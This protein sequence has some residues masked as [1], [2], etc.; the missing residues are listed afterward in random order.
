MHKLTYKFC[1]G[2]ISAALAGGS[3]PVMA[4]TMTAEGT[5]T[6][7]AAPAAEPA[8]EGSGAEGEADPAAPAS[9]E[10]GTEPA[11]TDPAE[12]DPAAPASPE[13]GTDPAGTDP[14]ETDPAEGTE[15]TPAEGGGTEEPGKEEG[16]SKGEEKEAPAPEE[17]PQPS[18]DDG[19][20]ETDGTGEQ[21]KKEEKKKEKDTDSTKE[22]KKKEL[23]KAAES[24]TSEE[25]EERPVLTGEQAH[26]AVPRRITT[27]SVR[28]YEKIRVSYIKCTADETL[29][30]EF[31][32]ASSDATIVGKLAK[33]AVV[34]L[35]DGTDP[36]WWYIE[37]KDVNGKILRGYADCGCFR[38]FTKKELKKKI[39]EDPAKTAILKA[40]NAGFGAVE[41]TTYDE[42]ALA[43]E[44]P[45]AREDLVNYALQFLGTPYV[46]DG[47]SLTDGTDC[48]GFARGVFAEFGISLPG[49]LDG[50]YRIGKKIPVRKAQPGDLIYYI[51]DKGAEEV[52]ICLSAKEKGL[53]QVL[54]VTPETGCVAV[55]ALDRNVMCRART[56][57]RLNAESSLSETE[58]LDL[59]EWNYVGESRI[60]S[61]CYNC[62][63]PANSAVTASG[64]PA[65]EWHTVAVDSSVIPLGS[66]V[67]IEGYGVFIAEDTGVK[68]KWCDIYVYNHECSLW[69]MVPVY[70]Q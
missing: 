10:E 69:D 4:D 21:D 30:R 32:D 70:Y 59:N 5:G 61:Y 20:K 54:Q 13:E 2:L 33:D 8:V 40:T 62:N 58:V 39:K 1:V 3:I 12:T 15:T 64:I 51:N 6:E 45:G 57:D 60:T 17:D 25:P 16:E 18:E 34:R 31:A 19:K 14:T 63:T 35:I 22:K 36:A 49:N 7:T 38:K 50:Q 65:T 44:T 23:E 11:G 26:P 66:K 46:K 47:T 43:K 29:V 9:P 24:E 52:M 53:I 28:H 56:F 48:V 42:L 41:K 55:R 27:Y 68:G 37:T 67:Y